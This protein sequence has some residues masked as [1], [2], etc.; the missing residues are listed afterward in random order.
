MPHLIDKEKG[1]LYRDG[2][3][4]LFLVYHPEANTI[5][6]SKGE[7]VKIFFANCVVLAI[8]VVKYR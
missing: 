5:T 8:F 2:E 6:L 7:V 1:S 4:F 3:D